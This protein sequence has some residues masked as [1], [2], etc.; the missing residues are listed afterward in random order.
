MNKL[1]LEQ[2]VYSQN[3]KTICNL[4]GCICN[5]ECKCWVKSQRVNTRGRTISWAAIWLSNFS[6]GKLVMH[7]IMKLPWLAKTKRWIEQEWIL[8]ERD[9]A[10][11][12]LNICDCALGCCTQWSLF[13]IMTAEWID[14]G[15]CM[16][17]ESP[18]IGSLPQKLDFLISVFGVFWVPIIHVNGDKDALKKFGWKKLTRTHLLGSV[19]LHVWNSIG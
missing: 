11:M 5:F 13:F 9:S 12:R 2:S 4:I 3:Y 10:I 16:H 19:K 18:L 7:D 1:V 6:S 17:S 15:K 14:A 8:L